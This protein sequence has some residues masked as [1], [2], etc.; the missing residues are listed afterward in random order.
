MALPIPSDPD[1]A[2]QV[3]DLEANA[4]LRAVR[5]LFTALTTGDVVGVDEFVNPHFLDTEALDAHGPHPRRGPAR[6]RQSVR[7]L[8]RVFADLAF[9]EREVI[10][11]DDRV[12]VRGVMRGRHV[13]QVLGIAPTGKHV[14]VH[15]IHIFRLAGEKVVEHRAMWGELSLL[16]QLRAV[17]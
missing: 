16:V 12:M 13:G 11:M 9:E 14:E 4:N 2:G 3:M 17:P 1:L 7:W 5:R 8:H 6:F 15:Q 10:A